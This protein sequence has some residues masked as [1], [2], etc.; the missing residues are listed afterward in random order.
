MGKLNSYVL[1]DIADKY[2]GIKSE[3][4]S[5]KGYGKD[6]AEAVYLYS[7]TKEKL[8]DLVITK[9][10]ILKELETTNVGLVEEITYLNYLSKRKSIN[11]DFG[12]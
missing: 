10:N 6:V 5:I 12:Y 4:F 2:F 9:E 8:C 7:I 1:K 3:I 11:V